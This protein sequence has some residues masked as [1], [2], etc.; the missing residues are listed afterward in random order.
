MQGTEKATTQPTAA[1]GRGARAA[2]M[3]MVRRIGSTVYEVNVY[4]R[5]DAKE[6]MDDKIM[7]IIRNDIQNGKAA[8]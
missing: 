2:T 1:T 7:R 6:T 8:G 3:S 5:Q 4:F